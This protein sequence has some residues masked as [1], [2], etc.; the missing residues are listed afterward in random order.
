LTQRLVRQLSAADPTPNVRRCRL[1]EVRPG[2]SARSRGTERRQVRVRRSLRGLV[3]AA[4]RYTEKARGLGNVAPDPGNCTRDIRGMQ[5]GRSFLCTQRC[6][7]DAPPREAGT[8]GQ[9]LPSRSLQH[10]RLP[11]TSPVTVS[12]FTDWDRLALVQATAG[13]S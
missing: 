4:G 10:D 8:P 13:Q 9:F 5:R 1:R 6:S 12:L 7:Q 2:R 11:R 3:R